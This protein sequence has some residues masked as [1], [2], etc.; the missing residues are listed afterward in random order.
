MLSREQLRKLRATPLEGANKIARA[1]ELAEVTQVQV[2]E[3]TSLTQSYVSRVARGLY[4]RLPGETMREFA[5]FFGCTI[6][7][8]F[9]ARDAAAVAS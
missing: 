3:G 9:P 2:A 6:E 4:E 1:M 8:L 7:D 5:E